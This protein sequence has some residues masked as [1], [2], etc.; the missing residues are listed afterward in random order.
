MYANLLFADGLAPAVIDFS[1]YWRPAGWARAV[2][3][4]DGLGRSRERELVQLVIDEPSMHQLLL[5]A[6]VFRLAASDLLTVK[7]GRDPTPILDG[8]RAI[9][10]LLEELHSES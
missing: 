9:V 8:H 3:V 2:Y 7:L 6:E 10:D 4:I 1:P 5:R